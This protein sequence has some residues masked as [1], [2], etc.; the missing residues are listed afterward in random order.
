MNRYGR[1]SF[2]GSISSYNAENREV[3]LGPRLNSVY[4]VR[5]LK[6]QGFIVSSF[7]GKVV[8][9]TKQMAEWI[10]AGKIKVLETKEVGIANIPKG[11]IKLFT[12]DKVGK[13]IID[14]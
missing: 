5:E 12:G 10:L 2:C 8:E 11:I 4:V 14:C 13:M 3:E 9:A 7:Y 1:I 6:L